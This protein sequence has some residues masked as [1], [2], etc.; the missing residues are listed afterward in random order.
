MKV[1]KWL[2]LT[3]VVSW[4]L[5]ILSIVFIRDSEMLMAF[6]VVPALVIFS[7]IVFIFAVV[8]FFKLLIDRL[9]NKNMVE[10]DADDSPKNSNLIFLFVC[11]VVFL[12][13]VGYVADQYINHFS[14]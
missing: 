10:L 5:A 9:R 7:I 4:V 8:H 2:V 3:L 11:I 12:L 6:R 14:F 13:I 1:I